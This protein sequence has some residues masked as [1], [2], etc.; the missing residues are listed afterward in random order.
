MIFDPTDP[1]TPL[2][3]LP[4]EQQGSL[5][6]IDHKDTDR[7]LEM[8]VMPP[9]MNRLERNI[10][11][12]LSPEGTLTGKVVEKSIGQTAVWERARLRQLSSS[13]YSRMVERWISLGATGA[14]ALKISPTDNS[15]EGS[16]N[17]DVEFAANSY[18]Q[19][20]QG[21]LM[22]FKPA[23]VGRLDRLSFT[24][25]K[26]NHPFVIDGTTYSENVKIKLPLGFVVDELP[27]PANIESSFGKYVVSYKVAGDSLVF[28]RSLR[29]D[30]ATIPAEKYESIRSFFGQVHAVEQS[31][32]VLI[33]K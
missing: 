7:L 21:R 30:R 33:K 5:A 11:A 20:M 16:F 25:G 32:V 4:E 23:I 31:P 13:D 3:D 26:R 22:V 27:E 29:L 19:I 8:P 15:R 9:E 10:E 17:L 18:A 6:L 2:G 12:F 24:E 28:T 1:Y 14:K